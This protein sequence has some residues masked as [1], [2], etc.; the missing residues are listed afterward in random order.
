ME[1][2]GLA[3]LLVNLL[4]HWF[5]WRWRIRVSVDEAANPIIT[6]YGFPQ[7]SVKIEVANRSRNTI[8]IR[9][10]RLMFASEYGF[11]PRADPPAPPSPEL[12][13]RL[14]PGTAETWHF[15]AETIAVLL[16]QW[17]PASARGNS[18][19]KLRPLVVTAVGSSHRGKRL[20]FSLDVNA[21]S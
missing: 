10:V 21:H 15:P 1:A 8:E 18:V 14:E 20:R 13:L 17:S 5:Y 16:Q 6:Q 3:V 9:D 19:A 2:V 11:P 12:P 7:N 4:K